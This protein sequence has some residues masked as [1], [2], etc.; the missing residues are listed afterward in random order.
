[1]T[2]CC[3]PSSAECPGS[4]VGYPI[5]KLP[6]PPPL[7]VSFGLS[8]LSAVLRRTEIEKLSTPEG[9]AQAHSFFSLEPSS[10]FL[11]G[12]QIWAG[13][14]K[15]RLKAAKKHGHLIATHDLSGYIFL[16]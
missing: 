1:V 2:V 3:G 10:S 6:A 11:P 4:F 13:F 16:V 7:N 15:P 8:A 14:G 9:V 12:W 5:V